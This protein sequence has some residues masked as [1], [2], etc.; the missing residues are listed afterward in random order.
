MGKSLP[1]PEPQLV[2]SVK[3]VCLQR[4]LHKTCLW[5]IALGSARRVSI[6]TSLL[7]S[8]SPT[9]LAYFPV[10]ASRVCGG[11]EVGCSTEPAWTSSRL[12]AQA[13]RHCHTSMRSTGACIS[14]LPEVAQEGYAH[15]FCCWEP[16][17]EPAGTP[18]EALL[19][20]HAICQLPRNDHPGSGDPLARTSVYL[21]SPPI[22]SVYTTG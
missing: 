17:T 12:L 11:S 6:L 4:G 8:E 9:Y 18:K 16:V 14:A 20:P 1:P 19:T 22:S 7:V 13:A 5:C 10:E 21:L 3:W 15:L 2:P